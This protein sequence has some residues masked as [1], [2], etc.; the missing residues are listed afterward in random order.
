[1]GWFGFNK[2]DA[3]RAAHDFDTTGWNGT[4]I[5]EGTAGR[6][7]DVDDPLL[8]SKKVT[9]SF[10]TGGWFHDDV[11]RDIPENALRHDPSWRGHRPRNSRD[12]GPSRYGGMSPT[13]SSS[14]SGGGSGLD[15]GAFAALFALGAGAVLW[16]TLVQFPLLQHFTGIDWRPASNHPNLW[17]ACVML[18]AACVNAG[19][20]AL[21]VGAMLVALFKLLTAHAGAGA[22]LVAGIAALIYL[23][24]SIGMGVLEHYEARVGPAASTVNHHHHCRTRSRAMHRKTCRR[25]DG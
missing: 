24:S 8:G 25:H 9:G 10:D 15:A 6:I 7:L 12:G 18:L 21:A 19:A 16:A 1:M 20:V 5:R 22:L 14:Y 17:S 2:G 4:H 11:I 13:R 23:G 3:V